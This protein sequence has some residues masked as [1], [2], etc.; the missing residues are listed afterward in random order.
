MAAKLCTNIQGVGEEVICN[1]NSSQPKEQILLLLERTTRSIR[2][3]FQLQHDLSTQGFKK[4]D[5]PALF[6]EIG[7]RSSGDNTVRK[8]QLAFSAAILFVLNLKVISPELGF[9]L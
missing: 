4:I 9:I 8:F 7:E 2:K 6:H 5:S 3:K 1:S